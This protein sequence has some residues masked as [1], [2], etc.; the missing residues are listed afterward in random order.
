MAATWVDPHGNHAH[1][2]LVGVFACDHQQCAVMELKAMY[3]QEFMIGCYDVWRG[4]QWRKASV[5]LEANVA[6]VVV[7]FEG[8][9]H[10][11]IL[12]WM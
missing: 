4:S 9:L 10:E 1:C 6:A 11:R 2:G 8:D 5:I 3:R 7:T 12:L